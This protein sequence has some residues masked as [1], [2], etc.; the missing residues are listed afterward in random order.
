VKNIDVLLEGMCAVEA[1]DIHLK[2]G[3]APRYRVNGDLEPVA[4]HEP[5]TRESM[6]LMIQEMLTEE[7]LERF[8]ESQEVDVSYGDGRNGRFRCNVFLDHWGPS[9]AIRRLPNRIPTL[10]ELNL[11]KP[12]EYF[13]HLQSGLVLVTGGTGSGKTSTLASLIDLI[14][15]QYRRH[16]ITLE[17]PIEYVHSAKRSLIHQ[18]GLHFDILSFADGLHDALREDPDVLLVGEL[19]DQETIRLA[20]GAAETGV[21]VFATLHTNG[22]VETID[23]IV[24]VF[25][26]DEQA[27]VR[28]MLSYSLS[29]V[30]SQVLLK[31]IDVAGR[32]PATEVLIATPA[33]ANMIREQKTIE[34]MNVLQASKS[35]GMHTLD[36][37]LE[38]MVRERRVSLEDAFTFAQNKQRFEKLGVPRVFDQT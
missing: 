4:G 36:D 34:L 23:R 32:L 11:P 17:D 26:A 21:L 12:I 35:K 31:R 16:I 22:A 27:Q 28:A 10:K 6:D 37:S 20:L 19:R 5:L 25:P 24:D 13:A 15:S 2:V 14:N 7:Q 18:R 29:G 30:V 1:S 8:Q 38:E 9:A 33:V 3:L